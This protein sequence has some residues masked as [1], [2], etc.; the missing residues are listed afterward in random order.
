MLG[1]EAGVVEK[2]LG[3]YYQLVFS[4]QEGPGE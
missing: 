4:M 3:S 2:I 1:S